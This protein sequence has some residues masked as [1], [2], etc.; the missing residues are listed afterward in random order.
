MTRSSGYKNKLVR[1]E[2]AA[3]LVDCEDFFSLIVGWPT[4]AAGASKG[5]KS[6]KAREAFA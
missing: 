1:D 2:A 3:F 4:E 5:S 6:K